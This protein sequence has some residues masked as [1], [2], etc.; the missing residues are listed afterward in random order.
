MFPSQTNP[1]LISL[2]FGLRRAWIVEQFFNQ[3][4]LFTQKH[5]KGKND[6][7]REREKKKKTET[8]SVCISGCQIFIMQDVLEKPSE[9]HGDEMAS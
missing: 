7:E 8:H 9:I 2:E 3:W 4:F 6:L 5:M 1:C